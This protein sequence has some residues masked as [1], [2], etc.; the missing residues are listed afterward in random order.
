MAVITMLNNNAE[1]FPEGAF[2]SLAYRPNGVDTFAV[3]LAEKFKGLCVMDF[4]RNY[5]DDSDFFMVVWDPVEKRAFNYMFATTRGWS[6]PC[7][8][9]YA[10]APPE[11]VAEYTA[12]KAYEARKYAVMRKRETRKEEWKQAREL[13]LSWKEFR[14]LSFLEMKPALVPLLKTKNFRSEFRKNL[15][16]QVRNWLKDD[17]PKF[18]FPLSARQVQ[19]LTF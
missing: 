17:N 2:C 1:S 8:G 5:Y 11:I 14:K 6:Y 15:A 18:K 10:D 16:Q 4:E 9:S 7:Y 19:C 12:W 13:N 3:V